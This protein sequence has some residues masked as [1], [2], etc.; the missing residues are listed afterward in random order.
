MPGLWEKTGEVDGLPQKSELLGNYES[1]W[2]GKAI[3]ETGPLSGY[4]CFQQLENT[5]RFLLICII[6]I[7]NSLSTLIDN[8]NCQHIP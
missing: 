7:E 8:S 3:N 1:Q 2:T 4:S 6:F 5:A